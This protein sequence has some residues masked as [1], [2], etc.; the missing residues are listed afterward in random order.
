MIARAIHYILPT[1]WKN[2]GGSPFRQQWIER[3]GELGFM[4]THAAAAD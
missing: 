3:L 2:H 4:D 1:G